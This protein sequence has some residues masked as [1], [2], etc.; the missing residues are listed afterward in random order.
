MRV[1][2]SSWGLPSRLTDK[3][4]HREHA[5]MVMCFL[6]LCTFDT[7]A[8]NFGSEHSQLSDLPSRPVG[9]LGTGRKY[10]ATILNLKAKLK[11]IKAKRKG[12]SRVH[13]A[14]IANLRPALEDAKEIAA[15]KATRRAA[16]EQHA[17]ELEAVVN[18]GFLL[19]QCARLGIHSWQHD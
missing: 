3:H 14:E 13:W 12:A 6:S 7:A 4:I 9:H 16:A 19:Q 10:Q 5:C 1:P 11:E 8:F 15:L 2:H 18:E 17:L